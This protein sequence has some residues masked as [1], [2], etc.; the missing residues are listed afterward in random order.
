MGYGNPTNA[1][2]KEM[3]TTTQ[4]SLPPNLP[5]TKT[6]S[7]TALRVL[8]R[9]HYWTLR[10]YQYKTYVRSCLKT[11]LVSAVETILRL[12]TTISIHNLR[13]PETSRTF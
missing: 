11:F 8:R 13:T 3:E 2:A 5:T 4:I 10:H 9:F 12:Y 6:L 1:A 7:R